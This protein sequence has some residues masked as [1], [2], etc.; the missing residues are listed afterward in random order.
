LLRDD[1]NRRHAAAFQTG[2][3][4]EPLQGFLAKRVLVTGSDEASAQQ[5]LASSPWRERVRIPQRFF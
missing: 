5:S 4:K 1:R 2:I 3:R